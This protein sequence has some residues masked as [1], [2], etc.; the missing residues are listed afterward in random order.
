MRWLNYK[1]CLSAVVFLL[2]CVFSSSAFSGGEPL[3]DNNRIQPL[4]PG[5]QKAGA[6]TGTP[7]VIYKAGEWQLN[8]YLT[9]K[10][11]RSQGSHGV[12]LK[13]GTPVNATKGETLDTTIGKVQYNGPYGLQA[14]LWD[15][16]GWMMVEPKVTPQNNEFGLPSPKTRDLMKLESD[17][18]EINRKNE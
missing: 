15:S 17:L 8:V 14:H 16:S 11:S 7:D 5:K 9:H 4:R 12:L 3:P 18:K 6:F 2:S 1:F 10:G 13:K